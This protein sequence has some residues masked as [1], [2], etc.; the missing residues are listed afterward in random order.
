MNTETETTPR[1][2]YVLAIMHRDGHVNASILESLGHRDYHYDEFGRVLFDELATPDN[3]D[4]PFN[5]YGVMPHQND[6]AKLERI[7][8]LGNVKHV[9]GSICRGFESLDRVMSWAFNYNASHMFLLNEMEG[10]LKQ[11]WYHLDLNGIHL[12]AMQWVDKEEYREFRNLSNRQ[13][14]G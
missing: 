1:E 13:N 9:E 14:E 4:D 5:V 3:K 7:E 2:F 6:K 8:T 10:R 12:S 11:G